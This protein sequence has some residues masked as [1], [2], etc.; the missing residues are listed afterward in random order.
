MSLTTDNPTTAETTVLLPIALIGHG[1]TGKEIERLAERYHCQTRQIFTSRRPLIAAREA[2]MNFEVAIDFSVPA[3]AL[4]NARFLAERG[5][6]IV[7]GTTGWF[8][9]GAKA[10]LEEI[11][12]RADGSLVWGTNFS[13]GVQILNRLAR[14]AAEEI[15][16][17]EEYDIALHELHHARKLDA[18]SGTAL[19]LAQ[20]LQEALPRRKTEILAETPHGRIPEAA[21]HVSSTRVGDTP[22]TH[23]LYLDSP[24]DTIEITHRARNRSGFAAGALRAA[25]WARRHKG[26][27]EFSEIFDLL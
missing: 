10:E 27:K 16:R 7:L 5:K 8:S 6:A 20:I 2:E 1:T 19:T 21:L 18:P 25:H 12:C 26:V 9:D 17:F 22:G 4:S 15:A 11:I 23:T 14:R 24:A 13:V 3:A